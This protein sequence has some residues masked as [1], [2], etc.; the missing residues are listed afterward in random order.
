MIIEQHQQKHR[1]PAVR[2]CKAALTLLLV[3]TLLCICLPELSA[4]ALYF[5]SDGI[6]T[7]IAGGTDAADASRVVTEGSTAEAADTALPSGRKVIIRQGEAELYATSRKN[8]TV[9][10]LLQRENVTLSP[11]DMVFV[12][13]SGEDVV[14]EV[15]ADFT[16]YETETETVA[17]QTVYRT[18]YT[19]PKGTS[20]VTQAGVNG[21]RAITYEVIY[22]D[23]ELVSRQ[24]VSEAVQDP[25]DEIV[26]V[27]ALVTEAQP[28]DTIASVD[29]R[30]DG[31]GYLL[32]SSGDALHF[33]G[34]MVVTCTAYS[35]QQRTVGTITATGTTVEVGVVA[36]DKR[37]IPLGSKL[38]IA[39]NDGAYTYGMACAEDTGVRGA[40]VDLY[41]DTIYECMQFGRR[42][43]TVYF[44]DE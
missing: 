32:L 25:V 14:V 41:M 22:A 3:V 4:S 42:S 20:V 23:G 29:L 18:D 19:V 34:T 7:V 31:S 1:V 21:S 9:S 5:I 15:S 39:S 2:L 11:L 36:V 13:L 28:G 26:S 30:E 12:D 43:G 33:S 44:L 40:S 37:V 8:E 24:S 17:Y 6:S 38:F 10:A 27:G 16:F 35:S